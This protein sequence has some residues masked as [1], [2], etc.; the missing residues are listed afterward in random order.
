VQV[1]LYTRQ[2]CHL[3]V[4]AKQVLSD[5]QDDY[6]FE[7]IEKDIESSDELTEK[8]G[9]MIPVIEI[10]HEMIQYGQIDHF[11]ISKRLQEKIDAS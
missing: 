8:Y 9:L 1:I 10:D 11:T 7:I 3:C 4:Q 2:K 5:L 6:H